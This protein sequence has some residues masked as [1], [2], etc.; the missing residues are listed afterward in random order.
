MKKILVGL[1]V[2]LLLTFVLVLFL[3][4]PV[5]FRPPRRAVPAV[6]QQRLR[7]HVATLSGRLSP[8]DGEHPENLQRVARYIAEEFTRAGGVVSEQTYQV[9]GL[10]YSN[11]MASFGGESPERIVVGAHY[12]AFAGLP[13]ADD[14]ASGVAGLLEL[15]WLLSKTQLP[16]QVELVAYPLEEPPIFRS[17][18]MGSMQH[19]R[20]LKEQQ[21]KLRAMLCLE[22]IGYFS[23]APGSQQYPLPGLGMI[24]GKQGNFIVVAG[25]F[26]DER[27]VRRV[28]RAMTSANDLPV[29]SINAL[30]IIPG[31]DWSDHGSYWQHGYSAA[32][33]TDTA[34]YR[35]PHYHSAADL[36]ETLDYAR[37][38]QVVQ[39]VYAAVLDLAKAD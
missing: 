32:M 29:H 28:K 27:L 13:G 31:I 30:S 33:I 20:R 37:M 35:N 11:V 39:Q 36:P 15:A 23:D 17:Q 6:D 21:V 12:D 26:Q 18:S 1:T 34:F 8:R 9:D 3:A 2:L 7:T 38:A 5:L 22:M 19:A 25:R 16:R 24:Y 14:N 4:Q 10:P